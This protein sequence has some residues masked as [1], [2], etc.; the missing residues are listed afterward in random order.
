MEAWIL[1]GERGQGTFALPLYPWIPRSQSSIVYQGG[2]RYQY[3]GGRW[4][5]RQE[6]GNSSQ[7][8]R[9][10]HIHVIGAGFPL[11]RG[12]WPSALP[13]QYHLD[14]MP[15]GKKD[16][17]GVTS[18]SVPSTDLKSRLRHIVPETIPIHRVYPSVPEVT[19]RWETAGRVLRRALRERLGLKGKRVLGIVHGTVNRLEW[20]GCKEVVKRMQWQGLKRLGLYVFSSQTLQGEEPGR[21][22]IAAD[23]LFTGGGANMSRT[24][25]HFWAMARGMPLLTTDVGDHGEWVRHR[26]NGLLL[27]PSCWKRDLARYLTELYRDSA[28]WEDLGQNGRALIRPWRSPS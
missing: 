22:W 14:R 27:T 8:E 5:K 20:E 11:S 4:R 18:I 3:V 16:W 23:W 15:P 2:K 1:P 21:S 28:W 10:S 6:E 24:P 13:V 7:W 19:H 12:E 25:V 17:R 26:H 9:V